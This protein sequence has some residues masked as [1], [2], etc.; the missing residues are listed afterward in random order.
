MYREVPMVVF[1]DVACCAMRVLFIKNIEA[2]DRL[3]YILRDPRQLEVLIN[4]FE[5][6]DNLGFLLQ[7]QAP[8]II[9]YFEII[10]A[11]L[12]RL[13]EFSPHDILRCEHNIEQHK[14]ALEGVLAQLKP[15][16][17]LN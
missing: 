11:E 5:N 3:K 17:R 12:S 2:I 6:T 8:H 1:G 10:Q 9:F 16:C 14:V 13:S 15:A 7:P 4:I